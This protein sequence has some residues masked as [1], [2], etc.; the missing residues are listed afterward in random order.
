[1]EVI[2]AID[3]RGG[4]V[5]RLYQGDF[6]RETLYSS[7]PTEVALRWQEAGASRIHIVDLDGSRTGRPVNLD[8]IIEIAAMVT[9]PLQVG[10][11]MRDVLTAKRLLDVGVRRVVFGTAAVRDPDM[12]KTACETLGAEAV[13]VGVDSRDGKVAVQGWEES[14]PVSAEQLIESMAKIGVVR[15]ICTDIATDGTMAGPNVGL[16]TALM[17]AADVPIIWAGGIASMDDLERLAQAGVEGAI[18]GSAIY[19]GT[20]DL[21]EAVKRFDE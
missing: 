5:V 21:H 10:G 7:D 18:V 15:F 11:G 16:A 19:E 3:L 13:V 1:M 8:T 12:V 6:D 4:R 2:P 17:K 20:I 14:V 9:T